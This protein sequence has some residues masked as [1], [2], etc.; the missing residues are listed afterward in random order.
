MDN[1]HESRAEL[2][3]KGA[4]RHKYNDY[5]VPRNRTLLLDGSSGVAPRG[6]S[7]DSVTDAPAP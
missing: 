1:S 6:V 3:D 2:A 7:L 4:Q 5:S